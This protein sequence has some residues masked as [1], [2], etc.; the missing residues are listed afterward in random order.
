[1]ISFGGRLDPVD[2]LSPYTHD[3]VP[4]LRDKTHGLA[5]AAVLLQ[6]E[7]L[8][9]GRWLL[10]TSRPLQGC[11]FVRLSRTVLPNLRGN[12]LC[13][14]R[15]PVREYVSLMHEASDVRSEA[16]CAGPL[17]SGASSCCNLPP[18]IGSAET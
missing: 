16:G 17:R 3:V 13:S 15:L 11:L 5:S 4:G 1:M 6:H 18:E 12:V 2:H 10:W 7:V 8:P 14:F 9:N